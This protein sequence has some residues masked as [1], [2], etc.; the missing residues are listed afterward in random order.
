KTL[1]EMME[2]LL[3]RDKVSR[4]IV[5]LLMLA[6]MIAYI[7]GQGMGMGLLF[8]EFTGA[9]PTYIILF[10]TA[11]FI[12]Y[13]YMGGMY[14]V[15]RVEFVIGMLVIGLGIVYYGSAFSLVHF[16]ASYLNH[17]L[18]AVGA[19]SLTTFHF[20]PSTITLFFTGMLG[21]LGAQIYWQRCFAAKDGKTARTG[22]L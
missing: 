10:V 2:D 11:V 15:A 20:D 21:V 19:Q 16:S 4:I 18:A 17:R 12:A 8:E 1:A 5:G 14:A 6:L 7:G 22:M 13:T 9:N 3:F